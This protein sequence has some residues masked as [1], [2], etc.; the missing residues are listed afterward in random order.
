MSAEWISAIGA[1]ALLIVAIIVGLARTWR[2]PAIPAPEGAFWTFDGKWPLRWPS[3]NVPVQLLADGSVS[4]MWR[5]FFQI[6]AA[7]IN[8]AARMRL[9]D[10]VLHI[11]R[12]PF[13]ADE[14]APPSGFVLIRADGGAD[15]LGHP[16]LAGRADVRWSEA[17]GL[18]FSAVVTVPRGAARKIDIA[19]HELGHALGLDHNDCPESMMHPCLAVRPAIARPSPQDAQRLRDLYRWRVRHARS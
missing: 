11:M 14:E 4:G 6:A 13:P 10:P 9:V 8:A 17:S 1:A 18:I 5:L 2:K 16:N 3:V 7:R 19:L 12:Q 15:P